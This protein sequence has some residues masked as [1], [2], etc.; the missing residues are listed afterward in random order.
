M[1]PRMPYSPPATP[2]MTLSFTDERR[3]GE[4]VALVGVRRGDVP[5]HAS[6]LRVERDDVRVERAH[7]HAV[8]ERGEPAVLRAAAERHLLR[9]RP[10]VV[11]QR[12][13]GAHVDR[14]GVVLRRRQYITPSMTS[15]VVSCE[16]R[17]P[18]LKHPLQRRGA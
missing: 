8:A 5:A 1:K 4:A 3:A 18:R 14:E 7:E 12:P 16:P 15:G 17:T 13:A 6:G 11:P 2:T 9:Q 10:L